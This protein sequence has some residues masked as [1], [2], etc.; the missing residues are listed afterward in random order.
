M[1]IEEHPDRAFPNF[2]GILLVRAHDSILSR[3]RA[4]GKP[5]AVRA[6]VES[7]LLAKG[8]Q[9]DETSPDF[10]VGYHL[11]LDKKLDVSTVNTHYGYAGYGVGGRWGTFG[12]PETRVREYEQGTL[13]ID[14]VEASAHKLVW[15]GSGTRRV[16]RNPSPEQVTERVNAAVAE[17]LAKF[18]PS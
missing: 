5:G 3:N 10:L 8:Y 11:S 1:L 17:I 4:S 2:L 6:A 15:R 14:V 16:S 18:P 12:F 7:T 13:I 9:K